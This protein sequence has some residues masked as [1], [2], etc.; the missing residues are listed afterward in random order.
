MDMKTIKNLGWVTLSDKAVVSDP[1]YD[2]DVCCMQTEIPVKP[3][4]YRAMVL[5]SDEKE[6]GVRVASLVLVHTTHQGSPKKDWET[7]CLPIGVDS[8]Q[9]GIFDDTVYPQSK[10]YPN[11]EQF[12]DECCRLTMSDEFAGIL[13]NGKGVVTSS[14]FGDGYYELL[15]KKDGD[16]CVALMLDY[17]LVNMRTVMRALTQVEQEGE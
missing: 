10:G 12:Y 11:A 4:K 6:W 13:K 7:I 2:R 9:C 1:S 17:D 16:C 15:A 14:G 8:G 3:G 5:L